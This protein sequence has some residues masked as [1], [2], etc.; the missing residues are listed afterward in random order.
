MPLSLQRL[1]PFPADPLS[2]NHNTNT[3]MNTPLHTEWPSQA[4]SFMAIDHPT[5][6]EILGFLDT[7]TSFR[8]RDESV[9][10]RNV[11]FRLIGKTTGRLNILPADP[12]PEADLRVWSPGSLKKSA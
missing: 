7:C 9:M 4:L 12:Q 10:K 2:A 3:P 5:E 8:E 11:A 6:D 1:N